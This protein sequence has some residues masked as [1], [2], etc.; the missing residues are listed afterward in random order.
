[1]RGFSISLPQWKLSTSSGL[2]GFFI[3]SAISRSR[4]TRIGTPRA[5][6]TKSNTPLESEL[7]VGR[8]RATGQEDHGQSDAVA[9]QEVDARDAGQSPVEHD[10]FRVRRVRNRCCFVSWGAMI[11]ATLED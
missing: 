3:E 9:S 2:L 8:L 7:L 10:D 11:D 4:C 1:M 5:L 6:S